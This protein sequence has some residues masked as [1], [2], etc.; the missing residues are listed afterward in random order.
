MRSAA[1][2]DQACKDRVNKTEVVS[3]GECNSSSKHFCRRYPIKRLP[4]SGVEPLGKRIE[5]TLGY[6]REIPAARIVP[7]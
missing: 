3:T 1:R 5:L 2:L 4:R 7:P 6:R